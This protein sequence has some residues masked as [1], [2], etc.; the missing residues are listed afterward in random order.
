MAASATSTVSSDPPSWESS[1][2]SGFVMPPSYSTPRT[3]EECLGSSPPPA[4]PPWPCSAAARATDRRRAHAG[5][6][7][8]ARDRVPDHRGDDVRRVRRARRLLHG[9]AAGAADRHQHH[10]PALRGQLPRAAGRRDARHR[11][12]RRELQRGEHERHD[13]GPGRPARD[14]AAPVR[15]PE[16]RA[17]TWSRS[18]SAA[19]T[20]ACSRPPSA[21]A[22]SSPRAT[23]PARPAGTRPSST[24]A[25]SRR[26]SGTSGPTWPRSSPASAERSP[27]ARIVVVGYPQIVPASGTCD[28]LPLAT[29]DYPVARAVN[30][31][32]AEAVRHGAEDADAEYVDLWGPSEGPLHSAPT[33]G[34]TGLVTSAS[35]ARAHHLVASS[36]GPSPTCS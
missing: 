4:W 10:L 33:R 27:Q 8:R 12:D 35:T 28:L 18:A 19:T 34:P 36:S 26:P 6:R 17:P 5:A 31:G 16:A 14:G 2:T 25:A 1:V 29:G 11:A 23:R 7:T 20:T 15:R 30:E 21:G 9:G 13:V 32:L 22:R 3:V 24:R